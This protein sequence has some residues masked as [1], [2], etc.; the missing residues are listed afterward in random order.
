MKEWAFK[1][2]ILMITLYIKWVSIKSKYKVKKNN[3]KSN[4]HDKTI[5]QQRWYFGKKVTVLWADSAIESKNS[6]F[7]SECAVAKGTTA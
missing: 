7:A 4:V 1:K 6:S 3:I 5:L 2:V